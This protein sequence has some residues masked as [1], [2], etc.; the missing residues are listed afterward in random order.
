MTMNDKCEDITYSILI[1]LLFIKI[2]SIYIELAT[3]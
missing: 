1:S 3:S 2:E